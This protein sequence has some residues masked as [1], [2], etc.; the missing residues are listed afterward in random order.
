MNKFYQDQLTALR[1]A[2][3]K[4]QEGGCESAVPFIIQR[5]HWIENNI[6]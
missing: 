5:I 1:E 3:K 4:C 6:Y 2:V